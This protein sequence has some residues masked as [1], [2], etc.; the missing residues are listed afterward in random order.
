M[1]REVWE[2]DKGICQLCGIR[3]GIWQQ[4]SLDRIIPGARGGRYTLE[5]VQAACGRCNARKG[6]T[7]VPKFAYAPL[8]RL[9]KLLADGRIEWTP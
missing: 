1:K 9:T 2:R 8:D 6:D 7:E 5:N 3:I 4:T